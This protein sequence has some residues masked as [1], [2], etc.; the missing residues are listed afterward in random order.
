MNQE[1]IVRLGVFLSVFALMAAW[2]IFRPARTSVISRSVR[3]RSNLA[4]VVIGALVSRVVLPGALVGVALWAGEANIG[5]FNT[6]SLPHWIAIGLSVLLLDIVIYWQH[7]WFHKVPLLWRL[8]QV[9]HADSHVD[10]T[11]GLRFHP[12]EII[13]SLLIKALAVMAL[14]VPAIAVVIFEVA[15]NGFA[16]FNHANIRL[17]RK[18]DDYLSRVLITQRLHR[19]HHSQRAR[20]SNTNFGFSVSWW[21]KLFGS[22]THEAIDDDN[23]LPLGQKAYPPSVKNASLITLLTLPFHRHNQN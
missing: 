12:L 8:H 1:V 21:D 19:I 9:H 11:T 5:L 14:G 17:P 6:L 20:E 3:W 23:H 2:E 15:L 4:M 10:T 22:Y 16:I 18:I 13:L 7:R